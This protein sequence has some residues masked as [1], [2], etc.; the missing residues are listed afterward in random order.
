M[1]I[2]WIYSKVLKRRDDLLNCLFDVK[3]VEDGDGN[4]SKFLSL[5]SDVFIVIETNSLTKELISNIPQGKLGAIFVENFVLGKESLSFLKAVAC[6][7]FAF[8]WN[9]EDLISYIKALSVLKECS[10][11]EFIEMFDLSR[12]FIKTAELAYHIANGIK[13]EQDIVRAISNASLFH[14]IG[15]VC[16]PASLMN[17]PRW[18]NNIE[19]EFVKLHVIY[20]A[21]F[22]K[23]FSLLFP[24]I[25]T[26]K[27]I[28]KYM[29][30]YFALQHHERLDGSGYILGLKGQDL[31]LYT[32]I[33]A[34]SDVYEA[35]RSNRPYRSQCDK[36]LAISFIKQKEATFGSDVV[37]VLEKLIKNKVLDWL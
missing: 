11:Q 3:I 2:L 12:H 31:H 17:A 22:L 23:Y 36:D 14:D 8:F 25:N 20:G 10:I 29:A 35:L 5:S 1:K 26:L 6:K 33:V 37:S 34:V 9:I 18:F 4:Y 24:C 16:L 19:E 30:Y 13:L 21:N 32:R 27:D 7:G 15:K 28:E